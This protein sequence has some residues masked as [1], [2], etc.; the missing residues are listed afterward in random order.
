MQL[1]STFFIQLLLNLEWDLVRYSFFLRWWWKKHA[2]AKKETKNKTFCWF[3]ITKSVKS[4]VLMFFSFF[5]FSFYIMFIWKR[6]QVTKK[7]ETNRDTYTSFHSFDG[8]WVC[9]DFFSLSLYSIGMACHFMDAIRFR[10]IVGIRQWIQNT[11][12]LYL[13]G[14]WQCGK[15]EEKTTRNVHCGIVY[16]CAAF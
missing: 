1:F 10:T 6:A 11:R 4:F 7:K 12:Y 3:I 15:E 5:S 13:C 9:E 2:Q 14:I 8:T 16:L